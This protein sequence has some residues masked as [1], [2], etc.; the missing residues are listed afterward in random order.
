MA[1]GAPATA[2]ALPMPGPRDHSVA[3]LRVARAGEVQ[4]EL[5]AHEENE[6]TPDMPSPYL[7]SS[8]V[9]AIADLN[10]DGRMEIALAQHYYEG[11]STVVF[12]LGVDG[13]A[14]EVLSIGCGA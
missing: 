12:E 1:V 14:K 5:L 9:A 3:F 13:T 4:T 8:R 11:S 7:L 2:L 10:G 6:S